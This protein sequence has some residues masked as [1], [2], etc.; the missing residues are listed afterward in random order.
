VNAFALHTFLHHV[1]DFALARQVLSHLTMSPSLSCFNY[2]TSRVLLHA[3]AN[4]GHDPPIFPVH[5]G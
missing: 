3:Q 4:L 1:S 5:L 2:F